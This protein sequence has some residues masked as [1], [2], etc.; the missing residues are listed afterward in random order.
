MKKVLCMILSILMLVSLAA[1]SGTNSLEVGGYPSDG[2]IGKGSGKSG[3]LYGRKGDDAYAVSD[4]MPAPEAAYELNGDSQFRAGTLTAAEQQDVMDFEKWLDYFKSNQSGDSSWKA[5]LEGRGFY[6][7]N[8]VFLQV[9]NN[10]AHV[11]NAKVQ[12][13][14]TD[15]TVVYE[16][17][18]DV[19]GNAVLYYSDKDYSKNMNISINDKLAFSNIDVKSI[20]NI[21]ANDDYFGTDLKELDLMFM[22]DTTGSMGDELRYIQTELVDVVKRVA[23]AGKALSI[24]ISVNFYRDEGDEYVVKYYDF[25]DNVEDMYALI[26][27]ETADGGGDFPEAVH[28]ALENVVDHKWRENAVKLCYLVLDAPPHEESEVQGV[29]ASLRK[30][31]AAAAQK[32]IKIIPVVA[33]GIDKPTEYLLRTF[34]VLTNGTYIFLTDDSGYGNSHETPDLEDWTVEPLNE[35]IIRVTCK[36]CG[37]PYEAPDRP[38]VVPGDDTEQKTEPAEPP[39]EPTE[40]VTEPVAEPTEPVVTEPVTPTEIT[41]EP[42][43]PAIETPEPVST[44][45]STPTETSSDAETTPVEESTQEPNSG[46]AGDLDMSTAH[47]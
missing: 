9:S 3:G 25:R 23:E 24:R 20:N 47:D 45:P 34:A 13:Q 44:E 10:G 40:P 22:I 2:V 1:C 12:L 15:G 14:K 46:F 39:V 43:T 5:S 30:S 17:R 37:L 32:G 4:G 8:V 7:Q 16:A 6:G 26:K 19:S 11:Y 36:F 27:S 18:T 41:T 31:I 28:T 33:S 29:N 21:G 42:T 38:E 35:C